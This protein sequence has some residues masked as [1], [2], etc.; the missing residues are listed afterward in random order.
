M[1]VE[2]LVELVFAAE[3]IVG[4]SAVWDVPRR[5]LLW[6]D[7]VGKTIHA[8]V[9][10]TGAHQRWST[11]DFVTSIGLRKDGG[12]I[13]G[14]SREI[15][16]WD[17]DDHFRTL[18][19]IEPDLPG[20]RLNEGVVGPDGAFWIGTMQNNIAP[21]GSPMDMTADTGRLY[22]CLPDGGVKPLS[23][24][25]FGLTNTL[26]WPKSGG[27]IT[28]DTGA[29]EI[30]RYDY[31]PHSGQLSN[32]R[33]IVSG[34]DRGLPDGSAMD[35]EGY[36]WNCRV[37]GGGCLLRFDPDG[38]VD[39][40]V[41]LPCSWPT[42]CA[43]GREQLDTLYVTSARFTMEPAQLAQN[44]QEGGVFRLKPGVSGLETHRFG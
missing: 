37:V 19:R 2:N 3:D 18:A 25:L 36:I 33:P 26:V 29:N 40:V 17:F 38:H 32:R 9:P 27:L 28:A 41:D 11:P 43:F 8:L 30:Y 4:E 16:L 10:E 31:D 42:S 21:D 20:N 23:N 35:A 34:F 15:C 5:R 12:A 24:D 22:R 14:L 1:M 39:R 13:V 7:I 6:V 44:P